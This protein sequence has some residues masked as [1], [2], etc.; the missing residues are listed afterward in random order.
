MLTDGQPRFGTAYYGQG[1]MR[2]ADDVPLAVMHNLEPWER[3]GMHLVYDALFNER[4]CI[5]VVNRK[6]G[7]PLLYI[8][9]HGI[10]RIYSLVE[11]D[12]L[13]EVYVG[14]WVD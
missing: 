11:L 2:H 4:R 10:K 9:A 14:H 13:A 7:Y 8:E 1:L 12:L 5:T 3:F 6:H